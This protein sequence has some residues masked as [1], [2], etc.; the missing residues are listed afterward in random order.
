MKVDENQYA[1]EFVEIT[2]QDQYLGR[3][4][5][6]RIGQSLRGQCVFVGQEINFLGSVAGTISNIYIQGVKVGFET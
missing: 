3:T 5:M 2:F 1:A 4:D 6:W